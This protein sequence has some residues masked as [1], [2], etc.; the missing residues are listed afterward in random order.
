M[1]S[2]KGSES[3]EDFATPERRI[4]EGEVYCPMY[5]WRISFFGNCYSDNKGFEDSSLIPKCSY[6]CSTRVFEGNSVEAVVCDYGVE[7]SWNF[8]YESGYD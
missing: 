4:V 2:L 8:S 7:D 3:F 6:A 5:G 1:A